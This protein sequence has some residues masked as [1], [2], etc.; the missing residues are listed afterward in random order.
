MSAASAGTDALIGVSVAAADTDDGD[1]L[2]VCLLGEC[3]LDVSGAVVRGALLTSDGDG[4][5]VTAAPSA[6]VNARIVGLALT[7]GTN[8]TI[9]VMVLPGMVQGA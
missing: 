4:K 9:R 2:N 3:Y 6:G 1:H 8:T 5:G 7:S